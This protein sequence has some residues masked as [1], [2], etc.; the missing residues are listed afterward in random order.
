MFC[1]LQFVE[2]RQHLPDLVSL[3]FPFVVLDIHS[4][5]A[6]P[7]GLED[8]VTRAALARFTEVLLANLEQ[9]SEPHASRFAPHRIASRI[10]F[11]DG[12]DNGTSIGTT[13]EI[14]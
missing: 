4:G 3:G 6:R 10:F 2:G 14:C 13:L 5:I 11:E 8:G 12:T 1:F 7:R 9:V